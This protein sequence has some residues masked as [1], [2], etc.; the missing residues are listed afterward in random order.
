MAKTF[1]AVG[2]SGEEVA[3]TTAG[4]RDRGSRRNG[5]ALSQKYNVSVDGGG[6]GSDNIGWNPGDLVFED[7]S[8]F[9]I[10]NDD[11]SVSRLDYQ[12]SISDEEDEDPG[13]QR[14]R[15]SSRA[16]H[17]SQVPGDKTLIAQRNQHLLASAHQRGYV[18]PTELIRRARRRP[19]TV[20]AQEP[21]KLSDRRFL[22]TQ[23]QRLGKVQASSGRRL[24][25]PSFE[26]V[27]LGAAFGYGVGALA[28]ATGGIGLVV[29]GAILASTTG[30]G[31]LGGAK[32]SAFMRG[33]REQKTHL[34]AAL[35]S[36]DEDGFEFT[37]DEARQL[38]GM[39]DAQWRSLLHVPRAQVAGQDARQE[40]RKALVVAAARHGYA[41]ASRWKAYAKELR[42]LTP[43]EGTRLNAITDERR[44][45]LLRVPADQVPDPA[46]R[47]IVR[48]SLTAAKHGYD[49]TMA[50][51][52]LAFGAQ[53]YGLMIPGFG[54][55]DVCE[56]HA[57]LQLG[58]GTNLYGH[59]YDQI[60]K[61][62]DQIYRVWPQG[63][64]DPQTDLSMGFLEHIGTPQL[65]VTLIDSERKRTAL[66]KIRLEFG[67]G[68]DG[69]GDPVAAAF[70]RFVGDQDGDG[71]AVARNLSKHFELDSVPEA[72]PGRCPQ[73]PRLGARPTRKNQRTRAHSPLHGGARVGRICRAHPHHDAVSRSGGR[74]KTLRHLRR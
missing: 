62:V 17:G 23:K 12:Q 37:V 30:A 13:D 38:T 27:G 33:P 67:R 46:G 48:R 50:K 22:R 28:V 61:F 63:E 14:P 52:P 56:L 49:T 40:V 20:V 39:T 4:R 42:E 16:S 70:K 9:V 36:L 74:R 25:W 24:R 5:S 21:E 71:A 68:D 19:G 44:N 18:R 29:V 51:K 64:V 8:D 72:G 45:E 2:Q 34:D 57:R 47:Q 1:P 7:R 32:G 53:R 55:I 60:D 26:G 31:M 66:E 6:S 54:P 11:A 41:R 15:A 3:V 65:R 59:A 58:D 73:D 69:Q 35:R 10:V 43:E